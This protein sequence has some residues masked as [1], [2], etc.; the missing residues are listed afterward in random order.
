MSEAEQKHPPAISRH[1]SE[2]Q[3]GAVDAVTLKL[4]PDNT[5]RPPFACFP[6]PL[7]AGAQ[8]AAASSS[9]CSQMT[10]TQELNWPL[11]LRGCSPDTTCVCR[12]DNGGGGENAVAY[13]ILLPRLFVPRACVR[14]R[15]PPNST[16][17]RVKRSGFRLKPPSAIF[18][19]FLAGWKQIR[20]QKP[21]KLPA[22]QSR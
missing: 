14:D 21:H 11:F 1:L 3:A 19:F 8:M 6:L 20:A 22:R 2:R 9:L 13:K 17:V 18:F 10:L 12:R 15:L 16:A 7:C 4:L 5:S